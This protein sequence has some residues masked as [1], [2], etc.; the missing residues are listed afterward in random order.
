MVNEDLPP[1]LHQ[2]A[3]LSQGSYIRGPYIRGVYSRMSHIQPGVIQPV[4]SKAGG[5]I[6]MP[7]RPEWRS[8]V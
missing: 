2:G 4:F 3:N 5:R 7:R 6:A 8:P 1:R